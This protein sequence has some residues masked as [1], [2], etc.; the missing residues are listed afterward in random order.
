[1]SSSPPTHPG[2]QD[3]RPPSE[4]SGYGDSLTLQLLS[5]RHTQAPSW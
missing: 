2:P 1:M 3:S 5:E 4:C